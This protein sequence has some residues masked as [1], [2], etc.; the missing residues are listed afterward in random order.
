VPLPNPEPGLVICYAYLW[1]SDHIKGLEEGLKDRP[2][3]IV[4]ATD[5]KDGDKIIT[6]VPITHAEPQE[7]AS[8]LEIPPITK[9]RLGLDAQRSWVIVSEVNRFIW[10]G[11]DLRPISRSDPDTFDYGLLPPAFLEQVRSKLIAY[12][13]NQK[14]SNVPR[15]K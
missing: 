4:L 5:T 13:K 9:K 15:T 8:S 10:P 3:A 6:V 7:E 14:L 12:A 2:C 1:H 11:P